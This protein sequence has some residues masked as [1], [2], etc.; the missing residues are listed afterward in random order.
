MFDTPVLGLAIF[1]PITNRGQ[2][3]KSENVFMIVL[4]F[5]ITPQFEDTGVFICTPLQ[6]GKLEK[7]VA[8]IN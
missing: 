7:P 5:I 4:L 3:I 8:G 6:V 1:C 2:N